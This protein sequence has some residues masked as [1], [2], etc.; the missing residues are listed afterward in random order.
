MAGGVSSF[1]HLMSPKSRLLVGLL[2]RDSRMKGLMSGAWLPTCDPPGSSLEGVLRSG[3]SPRRNCVCWALGPQPPS[4]PALPCRL[5]AAARAAPPGLSPGVAPRRL[6][7]RGLTP[8]SQPSASAGE[9]TTR[10]AQAQ[11]LLLPS[12][13]ARGPPGAPG[14]S[15]APLRW[16]DA[17]ATNPLLPPHSLQ[18]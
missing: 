7:G 17:L 15:S 16:T 12:S 18:T 5:V 13:A 2:H 3:H 10:S 4:L 11:G 8:R 9:G 6:R 1:F 14:G